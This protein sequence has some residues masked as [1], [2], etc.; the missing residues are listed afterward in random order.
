MFFRSTQGLMKNDVVYNLTVHQRRM[1]K[2]QNSLSTGKK[3]R[4]PEDDPVAA[5]NAMMYRTRINELRKFMSNIDEGAARLRF[6]ENG[7]RR[8]V[9][10]FQRLEE[11]A[12]Q[13]ANS[14]Y[15]KEDRV[16]IAIEVD[17][18]LKEAVEIANSNYKGE[19][20]FAGYKTDRKPFE[21]LTAR[22]SFTDREVIT[23]VIY[24]GDN[25]EWLREIEQGEYVSANIP[26]N[27][28]FWATNDAIV[29]SVNVANFS[30]GANY[31]I[32]IDGKVIQINA[33][34]NINT[35]I[36]KINNAK[37]PVRASL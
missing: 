24:N 30:A 15:A 31:K 29:G 3:V 9:E 34:D 36:N 1:D 14:T 37:I 22:P 25:G 7:V 32:R 4:L 35:I 12:V 21:V 19:Y 13:G 8:I 28:V 6:A 16:K 33:G 23:K 27:K 10:I 11:L 2:L 5:T 20:I 18:L 17:Q 26:G